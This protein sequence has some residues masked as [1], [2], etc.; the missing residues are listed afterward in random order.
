M[1][2]SDHVFD[3][4]KRS[5]TFF[6]ECPYCYGKRLKKF[7][8]EHGRQ[9]WACANCGRTFSGRTRTI[10]HSSKLKPSQIRRL[11]SMLS[12]GATLR[13][14]AHQAHVSLQ[15]ALLWKRKMQ[16]IPENAGNT[17]LSGEV[18]V[19]HTY[20]NAPMSVRKGK[21]RRGLSRHLLQVAA[22]IDSCGH[23]LLRLGS[24]GLAGTGDSEDAFLGHIASGSCVYHDMGHFGSCFLRC[25][26]KAVNSEDPAAHCLLNPVDRMCA[27]VKRMFAVHLRIHRKNVPL[28]LNEK[29]FQ[30]EKMG[31]MGFGGYLSFF[32]RRIFLSGKTLR[33]RDVFAL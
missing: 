16:R 31:S 5:R 28:W 6:G 8:K 9:R 14:A 24:W 18:W 20:I 3:L 23:V 2:F 11:V 29:A 30:R 15:T 26:E 17:V 10:L 13:Q 22:G 25:R 32:Y 21:K 19:D 1:C 12:D 7:G 4:R 27:Q 33:R